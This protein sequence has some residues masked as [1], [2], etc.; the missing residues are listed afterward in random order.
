MLFG[1]VFE[2][3][4]FMVVA[5]CSPRFFMQ[6]FCAAPLKVNISSQ[7]AQLS[8]LA[9]QT[10]S[11]EEHLN[12]FVPE[13]PFAL[14]LKNRAQ[15]I[16]GGFRI[17]GWVILLADFI[18]RAC[19]L[20]RSARSELSEGDNRSKM[21]TEAKETFVSLIT[22]SSVTASLLQW[23][24]SVR[25]LV[26]GKIV[27]ILQKFIY[28]ANLITS[29]FG[30]EKAVHI[31]KKEQSEL[32]T[33]QNPQDRDLHKHR[34]GLALVDLA[35]HISTIVWALLGLVEL[36]GGIALSPVLTGALFMISCGLAVTSL[37]YSLY[38]EFKLVPPAPP[39]QNLPVVELK[40][41][42]A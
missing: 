2:W 41:A 10:F 37:V 27:S 4:G 16:E 38:I 26:L 7:D 19:S 17:V 12:A 23:A 25:I 36:I 20:G 42:V 3:I 8:R 33:E 39:E 34:Y 14:L 1:T 29:G 13:S 18:N 9:V 11:A 24:D 22:F 21:H 32:E 40:E 35:Y 30:I 28:G 31:I 6:Q 5:S 15:K